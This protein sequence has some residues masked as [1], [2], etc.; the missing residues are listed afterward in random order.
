ME[1]LLPI[2]VGFLLTALVGN[3]LLH[4]WQVRTWLLQQ[5][6]LGKEKEYLALSELTDELA[7][8][9]GAR[10]YRMRRLNLV[11]RTGSDSELMERLRQYDEILQRWNE[12]LPSF[13]IRLPMLAD[14]HFAWQLETSIQKE[15]IEIGDAIERLL[16]TRRAGDSLPLGEVTRIDRRLNNLQGK[17]I[18][19]TKRLLTELRNRRVDVYYGK[20]IRFRPENLGYFST[21]Q[22]IKALFVR[23]VDALAI[24]RASLDS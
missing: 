1:A 13:Y 9:L 5:R 22:L 18:A 7:T 14:Y 24:G 4:G 8:L 17:A 20:K 21:W 10:I 6:F 19:F 12:R 16:T 23:D 2:V 3:R 15:F 11:F